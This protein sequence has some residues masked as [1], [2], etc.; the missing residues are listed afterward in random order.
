MMWDFKERSPNFLL[1]NPRISAEEK[2]LFAGL[3]KKFEEKYDAFDFFLVTSSGSSQSSG[4]SAKLVALS[5]QSILNSAKRVNSY[6]AARPDEHWGLVLP[7]FHV[8]G[9]GVRARAFLAGAQVF[10]RAWQVSGLSEWIA[11]NSIAFMSLVPAQAF[12]L[13]RENIECPSSVKK[14]FIGAGVLS[15]SLRQ[16]LFRLGWPVAE[17]Y[18]M[19]ETCSMIA[20]REGSE[21]FRVL[22][23]VEVCNPGGVLQIRCDS[24]LHCYLQ[25]SPAGIVS[26]EFQP[27]QWLP[28]EDI[29]E[30]FQSDESTVQ[31]EL[32]IKGR[33]GDYVKILGEG[34]S[35]KELRELFEQICLSRHLNM[36][37]FAIM[38]LADERSGQVL[39]LVAEESI[40]RELARE[41]AA[42]FN[43]RCRPYERLRELYG[44]VTLPRTALGK[45]KSEE[46]RLL[47]EKSRDVADKII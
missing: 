26:A 8:A 21:Y 6:L 18:G 12:D 25:Q 24:L 10:E 46:L 43:R 42:E 32:R 13:V 44:L 4:Q 17:T 47:L 38:A 31:T 14:I 5:R 29:V 1:L 37:H 28:T 20:V 36:K 3:K 9:V 22:P 27:E 11:Q 30:I 41:L 15:D 7:D 39:S 40:G 23:G 34:V 16:S 33:K 2:A 19:T 35:L 45:L